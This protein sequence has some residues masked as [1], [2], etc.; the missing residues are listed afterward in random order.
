MHARYPSGNTDH[1]A[2]EHAPL[3]PLNDADPFLVSSSTTIPPPTATEEQLQVLWR[4]SRASGNVHRHAVP[5]SI[6][7]ILLSQR[8]LMPYGPERVEL[9][10]LALELL[11]NAYQGEE[12]PATGP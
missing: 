4:I 3:P 12:K 9:T 2:H 8:L 10:N 1:H 11:I 6:L 7:G 5:P